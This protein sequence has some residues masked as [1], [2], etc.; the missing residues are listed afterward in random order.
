M[1]SVALFAM[2]VLVVTCGPSPDAKL[3]SNFV[4]NG[5]ESSPGVGGTSDTGGTTDNGSG[6]AIGSGGSSLPETGGK[7]GRGG[8]TGSGGRIGAG[9]TGGSGGKNG[10][11]GG[12]GGKISTGGRDGGGVTSGTGGSAS[13][14]GGFGAG[15]TKKDAGGS[16]GKIGADAGRGGIFGGFGDAAI[17]GNT[18]GHD[19]DLP[20]SPDSAGNCISQVVSNGYACG[21]TPACSACMDHSTSK[22]AG[23]QAGLDCLSKGG[24]SACTGSC[25]L[26]C[27]NL[28]GDSVVQA[29]VT[30]LQTAACGASGCGITLPP[31]GGG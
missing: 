14:A 19:A 7:S 25:L 3:P 11:D 18:G 24:G 12:Q 23:C 21:D 15:G 9:G 20:P 1:R 4:N 22:A 28:A 8:E 17:G 31:N 26:N 30:A 2:V 6:G 13:D 16:G 10:P 29:C 27:L 5:G